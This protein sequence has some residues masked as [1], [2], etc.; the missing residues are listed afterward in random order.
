[1]LTGRSAIFENLVNFETTGDR[2]ERSFF[3]QNPSQPVT[4][5]SLGYYFERCK[6]I[7][8]GRSAIFLSYGGKFWSVG[9][10]FLKI[11]WILKRPS[12][13]RNYFFRA[14][15]VFVAKMRISR[16]VIF[17]IGAIKFGS[18]GRR[19]F[20]A[21]RLTLDRSVGGFFERRDKILIGRSAI[22]LSDANKFRSV[23]RSENFFFEIA[24]HRSVGRKYFFRPKADLTPPPRGHTWMLDSC[25]SLVLHVR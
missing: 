11:W 4:F 22:F 6:K 5:G 9:R 24:D 25:R 18:V 19:F 3:I 15:C 17:L 1:M 13:G 12:V 20:W 2:A 16:S 21:T 10:R 8:T 23:G 7:L 14:K